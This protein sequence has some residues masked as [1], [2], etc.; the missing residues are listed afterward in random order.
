[1]R[2]LVDG[3]LSK[4][5]MYLRYGNRPP[6]EMLSQVWEDAARKMND[7]I[8]I[9]ALGQSARHP[10][11]GGD[12][13]VKSEHFGGNVQFIA[14]I[15]DS[16]AKSLDLFFEPTMR[17]TIE[18]LQVQLRDEAGRHEPLEAGENKAAVNRVPTVRWAQYPYT[19]IVVLGAGPDHANVPLSPAGRLRLEPAV[20]A[21]REG[22]AP[23][24]LVSGGYVN[25]PLTPFNEALEMKKALMAEFGVP[26]NVII[27]DPQA[28][29][30]I[31]N[32]RNAAR[33]IYRYNI[34]FD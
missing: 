22:K 28:R 10:F 19:V 26:E 5:G 25:P 7:T 3:P 32:M 29:I 8:D 21:Y 17:F 27:V 1:M 16:D 14:S 11:D 9:Y 18:L 34:P 33:L 2:Q 31:T 15:L 4:S 23:F 20:K 13:D 24:I 12:S 6:A 30:T